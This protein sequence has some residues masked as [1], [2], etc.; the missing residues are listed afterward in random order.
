MFTKVIKSSDILKKN[1]SAQTK[2][3]DA[4]RADDRCVSIINGQMH[5]VENWS[6]GGML[7]TA[8]ERIFAIGQDCKF[9]LKF[10]LRDKMMEIDH[11]AKV[12]RK[13]PNKIALQYLPLTKDAQSSFQKVVDDYVSQRFA[14][15][16]S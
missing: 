2:R 15:S 13:S 3:R 8:D 7:I 6:S 4:R 16:Q 14:E 9:T 1:S 10:K 5:P 12:I 11:N